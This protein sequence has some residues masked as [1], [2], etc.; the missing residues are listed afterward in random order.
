LSEDFFAISR[1]VSNW[2][3]WGR[4]DQRG[5]LNLVTPEV[6]KRAAAVVRQ[7]K[8]FRLGLDFAH[9]GPQ[10]YPDHSA[11][12]LRFNPKLYMTRVAEPID[13]AKGDYAYSDDVIHMPISASTQWDGIAH[14]QY[15]GH[16]YNGVKI[17]DGISVHGASHG[18]I[19]HAAS[20][21]ITSRAVLLDIARLKGVERLPAGT[22]IMPE[23]LDAACRA[24][25][26]EVERGDIVMVHTGHLRRW[27][28]DRDLASFRDRP[29]GLHMSCALWLHERNV[30]AVCADNT[31]VEP[32]PTIGPI[33]LPLH[34]L[35]IRDMG[36]YLGEFFDLHAL[37]A[38][39]AQDGEY[40]CLL[41]A[42]ALPIRGAVGSPI[43]PLAF[44]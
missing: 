41:V 13:P 34:M 5:T 11:P 4:E 39:C 33:P 15:D 35:C 8:L 37:A 22:M 26:S 14:I 10:V 18:G 19:E 36:L 28:H 30:V 23:D 25:K 9:D 32:T 16:M 21:G 1:R 24:Q 38:D 2:G 29:P 20:P 44:K 42:P 31:G 3:R 7:G 17:A 27:T 43:N 6:I 40:T 12:D